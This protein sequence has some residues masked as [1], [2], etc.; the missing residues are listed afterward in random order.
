MTS[1]KQ[2][3]N[4]QRH[5]VL[6]R[7]LRDRQT[8][9]RNRLRSLRDLMPARETEVRDAEEISMEDFVRDMDVALI[10]MESETLRRIDE[11]LA[12]LEEGSY[13]I[14]ASCEETIA[15]ARLQALPFA[16]LCRDCQ[17][18]EEEED[19]GVSRPG[20]RRPAFEDPSKQDQAAARQRSAWTADASIQRTLRIARSRA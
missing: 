13:G 2:T 18:R 1:R 16:T 15:E 17:E 12:R 9:I 20:S 6:D 4:D 10:V 11:A 5:Q 8:E 14:C 7:M 19:G 3:S